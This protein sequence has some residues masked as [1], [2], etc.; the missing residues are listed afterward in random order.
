MGETWQY[1]TIAGATPEGLCGSGLIDLLAELRRHELMTPKGV[2]AEKKRQLEL[3][4]EHGITFSRLDASNLAQA[5]AANYCGQ[6]IVLRALGL[7]PGHVETLYL[8]GG[9]ANYVDTQAAVA[10]GF[11]GRRAARAYRQSR[12]CRRARRARSTAL[13]KQA[14]AH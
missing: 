7:D 1:T 8:A 12:Q 9:F 4:P 5:K 13:A 2:F 6:Y 14:R 11:F 10:I 3:V